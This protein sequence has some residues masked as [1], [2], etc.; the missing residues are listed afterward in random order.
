MRS[1]QTL[2]ILGG[3]FGVIT[4]L[5]LF[6]LVSI[7]GEF[8]SIFDDAAPAAEPYTTE[9]LIILIIFY[10]VAFVIP[11][12]IRSAKKTGIALF[13]YAAIGLAMTQGIG[14][15]AAIFLIIAGLAAL[16]WKE[17][18]KRDE[19]ERLKNRLAE[20]QENETSTEF[21]DQDESKFSPGDDEKVRSK[22]QIVEPDQEESKSSD[23]AEAESKRQPAERDQDESKP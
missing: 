4:V 1:Y 22:S 5:V 6:A 9:V 19:F 3:V 11:F 18:I 15:F 17:P 23:D 14:A 21:K 10:C 12:V 2:S 16:R 7:I 8:M 13:V 20:Y